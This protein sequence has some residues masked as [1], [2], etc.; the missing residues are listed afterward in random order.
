MRTSTFAALLIL[1]LSSAASGAETKP[2][3]HALPEQTVLAMRAPRTG[4]FCDFI[5]QTKAGQVFFDP[6]RCKRVVSMIKMAA[7]TELAEAEA[8]MEEWGF[9][10]DDVGTLFSGSCGAALAVYPPPASDAD[11]VVVGYGWIEPGE[12]LLDRG[13]Q[14]LE[15]LATMLEQQAAEA[16]PE[17]AREPD[18]AMLE[19]TI[20]AIP[21]TQLR[22]DNEASCFLF[23][24][25]G[26]ALAVIGE[27][28]HEDRVKQAMA[29]LLIARG[30]PGTGVFAAAIEASPS[31][32]SL[33][34]Y[35]LPLVECFGRAKALYEALPMLE[36][37]GPDGTTLQ[38]VIEGLGL[39]DCDR[40]ALTMGA[41][42]AGVFT[43]GMF[44]EMPAPRTGIPALMDQMP[45][46]VAPP[47]WL[48]K[49]AI[50]YGLIS[51]DLASLY[52]GIKDMVL[53]I[54][55]DQEARNGFLNVEMQAKGMLGADM[56]T[57]L[58]AFGQE[59]VMVNL[60]ITEAPDAGMAVGPEMPT[61]SFALAWPMND[62]QI[63]KKLLG[64]AGNFL[65]MMGAEPVDEQGFTGHRIPHPQGSGTMATLM[66]GAGHLVI[67]VGNQVDTRMM[68]MLTNPPAPEDCF[69]QSETYTA[70]KRFLPREEGV[71]VGVT[72]AEAAT[73]QTLKLLKTQV[74]AFAQMM[75]MRGNQGMPPGM[76]PETLVSLLPSENELAGTLGASAGVAWMDSAGFTYLGH[77]EMPLSTDN[78]GTEAEVEDQAD[79]IP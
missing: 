47:A 34:E 61:Q 11:P 59:V 2:I 68:S 77:M 44:A 27:L 30:A 14:A 40:F 24:D 12:D 55:G 8:A 21:V 10:L 64:L 33:R 41:D 46:A 53:S 35:E 78:A 43:S 7:G 69:L 45:I 60:P 62:Q 73:V 5:M 36:P 58:A 54:T 22:I 67:C 74:R 18:F 16:D 52:N 3:W 56:D 31:I 9:T 48:S 57:V 19:T 25:G 13:M 4:E 65:G 75:M 32:Q 20:D 49:E 23:T 39:H 29:D 37:L 63:A 76:G 6:D 50:G 66:E 38:Q 26:R 51:C 79:T 15:R 42:S 72:D 71:M 17:L 70:A 1:C 28:R